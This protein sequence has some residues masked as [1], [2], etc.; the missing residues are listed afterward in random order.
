MTEQSS[1]RR[2]ELMAAALASDLTPDELQEFDRMRL[3]DPSIDREL[4]KLG[5]VTGVLNTLPPWLPNESAP[6]DG[7]EGERGARSA[8]VTALHRDS[9]R[10]VRF[11]LAAG[12]AACLVI[13]VVIG[14][15]LP[16]RDAA[17]VAGPPG[18]LGAAEPVDFEGEPAG[19]ETE[20]E[21]VA[22][23]WGTETVV[24]ISGLDSGSYQ[25]VVTDTGGREY[26]SGT[27]LA[28]SGEIECRLNAAVLREDV[29][30]VS[31][32]SEESGKDI[33]VASVP[34]V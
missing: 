34:K 8:A 12:A 5:E 20:A 14:A 29:A 9:G 4:A 31:I 17:P 6:S 28:A 19:V 7:A 15:L 11:A 32:R 13:G 23:T 33:A 21:L 27:F 16:D 24:Q 18:T 3:D 30:A 26:D 2:A 22:H 25:V 1:D 10:P